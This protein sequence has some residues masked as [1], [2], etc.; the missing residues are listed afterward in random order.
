MVG[1]SDL[2]LDVMSNIVDKAQQLAKNKIVKLPIAVNQPVGP[3]TITKLPVVQQS[4]TDDKPVR[5]RTPAA[6]QQY[7]EWDNWEYTSSKD[8]RQ[9]RLDAR[10]KVRV[11]MQL[12][13]ATKDLLV[14]KQMVCELKVV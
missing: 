6:V 9:Q 8:G 1:A 3:P 14:Y 12:G 10:D 7:A 13:A 11:E 5:R 2:L 4:M